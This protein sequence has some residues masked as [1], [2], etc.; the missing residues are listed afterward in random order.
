MLHANP[1]GHRV[2]CYD[3]AG[4]PRITTHANEG[5][6]LSLQIQTCCPLCAHVPRT[7]GNEDP[8]SREMQ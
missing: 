7:I 3:F 2:T 8:R 6:T 5:C 4:P 1:L